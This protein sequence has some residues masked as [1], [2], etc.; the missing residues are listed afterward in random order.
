[1]VYVVF[2]DDLYNRMDIKDV[3]GLLMFKNL[4][5]IT[6]RFPR[7]VS[8]QMLSKVNINIC[9]IVFMMRPHLS[10]SRSN[11]GQKLPISRFLNSEAVSMNH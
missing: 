7:G 1:M 2:N 6:S 9:F 11:N 4:P 8:V 10:G 3:L 5:N